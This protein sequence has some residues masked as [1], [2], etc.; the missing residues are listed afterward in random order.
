M[1]L[2]DRFYEMV[3]EDASLQL[4]LMKIFRNQTGESIEAM[5]A[6]KHDC[7][8]TP[9]AA[10]I[11]VAHYNE[12]LPDKYKISILQLLTVAEKAA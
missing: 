12:C 4:K 6:V 1:K 9:A 11:I 8:Q 7:F 10:K 3:A 2:Q 5:A